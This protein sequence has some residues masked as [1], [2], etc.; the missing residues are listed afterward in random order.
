MKKIL[1][2]F[3]I[4]LMVFTASAIDITEGCDLVGAD[5]EIS[6][7]ISKDAN[8]YLLQE[9]DGDASQHGRATWSISV[10]NSA[11]CEIQATISLATAP[12]PEATG[13][14]Y[15]VEIFNS[16]SELVGSFEEP[17]NDWGQNKDINLPGAV[18]LPGAD[19]YSVVLT[20]SMNW[21]GSLLKKVIFTG[22]EIPSV[23]F[24]TPRVFAAA[25]A[26]ISGNIWYNDA[27]YLY[28]N[29]KSVC[30]AASWAINVT[31]ACRVLATLNMNSGTSSGH[32]FH[33]EILKANGDIVG[34]VAEPS[35]TSD[36]GDIGVI[37]S[38]L[39]PEAGNYI[40]RLNNL[41]AWSSAKINSITLT[42]GYVAYFE[43]ALS[44]STAK[45]YAWTGE[46]KNANWPGPAME[47]TK[48]TKNGKKIYYY[49]STTPYANCIFNKNGD[50]NPKT[51][52]QA[53]IPTNDGKLFIP[54]SV[55][56]SENVYGGSWEAFSHD[57]PTVTLT[58]PEWATSGKITLSASGKNFDGLVLYSYYYSI[59]GENYSLIETSASSCK[60]TVGT[61]KDYWFKVIASSALSPSDATSDVV[62][63]HMTYYVAG[64]EQLMGSNWNG[65]DEANMM[66]YDAGSKKFQLTK[67]HVFL[68]ANRNYKVYNR[69]SDAWIPAGDN[70]TLTLD[71]GKKGYYDIVFEYNTEGSVVTATRTYLYP[72]V[73]IVGGFTNNWE[74]P[75]ELDEYDEGI[76]S[77]SIH[78][79][80]NEYSS[81]TGFR[82]RY[83]GNGSNQ[84]GAY[85]IMKRTNCTDWS[86]T[87]A[88]NNC[89]LIADI[90]G[91]Y[92]FSYNVS[93]SRLTITYPMEFSRTVANT[94]YGT[95]CL[96]C[97]A[98]LVGATAYSVNALHIEDNYITLTEVGT[99]LTAGVPY[100]IKPDAAGTITATMAGA[101]VADPV[102]NYLYGVWGATQTKNASDGV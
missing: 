63:T 45:C 57:D 95:L 40:V 100:I 54:S 12:N 61:S 1:S 60:F 33:I 26:A 52:D 32:R 42:K 20:N 89:G 76:L 22:E 51:T 73:E 69:G 4:L 74:D 44:W 25:D 34:E 101:A 9:N 49:Q 11:S 98:T 71:D 72:K 31:S 68:D 83:D 47:S 85:A 35:Q 64:D 15:K 99:S 56:E 55:A 94:N 2:L 37:G 23:D 79:N 19:T 36:P 14:R 102:N 28:Y 21:S 43:D 13:H 82:I 3:T 62:T 70:L 84:F 92:L 80:A 96:P 29:D 39:I 30:G 46:D 53:W 48:F 88:S 90:D 77:K 7:N 6:G 67:S 16:S 8:N 24:A 17:A 91:D 65:I 81:G 50:G 59:D 97:A 38:I 58:A 93:T 87:E 75:V 78:I 86:L 66:I 41:T 27:G 10:T 5:A 18:I